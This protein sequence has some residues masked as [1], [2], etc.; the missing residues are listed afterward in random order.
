MKTCPFCAEEIQDAAIVCKHCKR[1]LPRAAPPAAAPTP[2]FPPLLPDPITSHTGRS[3]L[4]L[5]GG[6]FL[7]GV[8]ILWVVGA[9]SSSSTVT[10][11]VDDNPRDYAAYHRIITGTD[12]PCDAVT[13]TFIAGTLPQDGSTY[14]SVQCADG[15]RYQLRGSRDSD[16]TQVLSCDVLERLGRIHCFEK[17]N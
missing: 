15:H 8:V 10:H 11:A 6:I 17:L 1:D 7:F 13:R 2:L 12:Q 4:L 5:I 14:V 16:S 3:I 9:V